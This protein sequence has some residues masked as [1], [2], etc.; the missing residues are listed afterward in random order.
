MG[1]DEKRGNTRVSFQATITLRF[2]DT[3]YENLET[4]DLSLRGV[5]VKGVS[6]RLTGDQCRV[7]LRLSGTSSDLSLEM[8]G[9]VVRVEKDGIGLHFDEIDL[10]SFYHLKNIV[11]FNV[12]DPDRL[13]KELPDGDE[14][15]PSLD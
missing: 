4:R 7:S 9:Q 3:T 11:Y 1:G 13:Q 15:V 14:F 2:A 5:F 8:S 10:D 12:G 6:G